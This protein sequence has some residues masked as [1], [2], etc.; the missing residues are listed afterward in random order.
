MIHFILYITHIM[1]WIKKL[2]KN[3]I[4]YSWIMNY[5][6]FSRCFP[7]SRTRLITN[8]VSESLKN[9]QLALIKSVSHPGIRTKNC[10]AATHFGYIMIWLLFKCYMCIDV[11]IYTRLYMFYL[12]RYVCIRTGMHMLRTRWFSSIFQVHPCLGKIAI[13]VLKCFN[14]LK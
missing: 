7:P 12:S 8:S 6:R 1:Q 2:P 9:A 14:G 5:H 4:D 10:Y 11:F 3:I 13:C